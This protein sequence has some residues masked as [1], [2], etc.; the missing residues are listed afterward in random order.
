MAEWAHIAGTEIAAQTT[1]VDLK[2]QRGSTKNAKSGQAVLHLLVQP[3]FALEF[4]YQKSLLIER[5]NMFFGYAAIN[6][7]KI[8][9]N[10]EVMNK[11]AGKPVKTR[12]LTQQEQ[13]KIED[14]VAT[15]EEND[16]QTALKN[17]GKAMLSRRETS[18][19]S[20]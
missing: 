1:P 13:K 20:R 6:D 12:L 10:S 15:V 14:I 19:G 2:L 8:T 9:Q 4:G 7:I 11:K 17:L 5:L 3:G 18:S 16:L